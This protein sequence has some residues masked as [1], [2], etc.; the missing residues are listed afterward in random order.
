MSKHNQIAN[1]NKMLSAAF[2]SLLL[3]AASGLAD[4]RHEIAFPDIAG[5]TTLKC[6]FHIHTVFSDGKV[7][8]DIRVEEAWREGLDAISITDHIEYL[9]HKDDIPK[10]L[11]RPFEI[12]S[13]KA[14][15]LGILLV[16]GAEMTFSTPPGHF[17]AL[18]VGDIAKLEAKELPDEAKNAHQQG[19]FVFWNHPAWQG[20]EKGQWT[21]L[22]T[23]L[24]KDG[25]M[26]GIE[27][28]NGDS[29]DSI[30]HQWCLEKNLTMVGGTDI[31]D[32]SLLRANTDKEHRT[33][34]LVFAKERTL[35]AVKEALQNGRTAVWCQDR[36]IGKKA[37]LEPLFYASITIQKPHTI[38]PNQISVN[39]NNH[40]EIS[41]TLQRKGDTGPM[42]INLPAK[43]TVRLT[44]PQQK[45]AFL[46]TVNNFLVAPNEGLQVRIEIPVISTPE[47]S[48]SNND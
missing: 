24:V 40:S 22:D 16:K 2:I 19:G 41:L 35:G 36:L 48:P 29:Y 44:M 6:D 46:Y 27:I 45:E 7:W 20:R 9:P 5:Y 33:L 39:I 21:D 1:K 8:P 30:A 3:L 4:T 37:F 47:K 28:C 18:F 34:T 43:E 13:P 11:N 31:H 17:N 25:L 32:P 10:N 42:E 38:E 23:T 26:N 12:A 14:A 15:K